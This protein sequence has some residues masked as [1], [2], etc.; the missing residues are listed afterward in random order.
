MGKAYWLLPM[1]HMCT[2]YGLHASLC[3]CLVVF[4]FS[5]P[6]LLSMICSVSHPVGD[7]S[8]TM[9]TLMEIRLRRGLWRMLWLLMEMAMVMKEEMK[10][11]SLYTCFCNEA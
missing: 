4:E 9:Q 8:H 3:Y 7:T 11:G 1:I 6:E 2:T 10:A 5:Q